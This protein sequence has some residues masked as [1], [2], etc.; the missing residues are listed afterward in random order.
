MSVEKLRRKDG[1]VVWVVRW[2]EGQYNRGRRFDRKADA[3]AFNAEVRRRR[4]AGGM[5]RID[6][7]GE[8]LDDYVTSRWAKAHTAHLSR[9]TAAHYTY[10]YDIHVSPHLGALRLNELTPEVI[11]RWQTERLAAGAG[12]T[13]VRQALELLRSMLQRAVESQ[14]LQVNPARLVKKA[15]R[16]RRAEVRPL[17][18]GVV[19]RMRAEASPRDAA[20]LSV[21]AYAGLRPGE[22]LAMR[23]T[24]VRDRTLLVERAVSLGGESDTKTRAHRTVR[25]LAALAA[26]LR[27]WR[28]AAGRPP[29]GA[30]LFPRS[31]GRVWTK[32]DYD[33]WRR[34]V[35]QPVAAGA[36]VAALQRTTV[37]IDDRH[38]KR[39][40]TRYE[41]PRPYDLRHSFASL[42]LHEGRSV[43]YVARQLGHGANL[44]TGTYGHVID[45]LEDAPRIGADEVIDHARAALRRAV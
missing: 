5:I 39:E 18:P 40:R 22:A 7:G 17:A 16:A 9:R 41:G 13:A 45:E 42:L 4:Q 10:L 28:M 2:R 25:L 26:D 11:A 31:D 30:L 12:R 24:D 36:G 38:R 8:T 32:T 37:A 19:E 29:D 33:N 3:L 27:E 44:T 1:T 21:L 20:L 43:I 15:Q 34:R 23:W 6:V 35:F 14:H